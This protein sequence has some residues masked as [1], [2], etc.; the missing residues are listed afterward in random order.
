MWH[1]K[2]QSTPHI[3]VIALCI[4]LRRR[5]SGALNHIDSAVLEA[6]VLSLAGN[7]FPARR[8]VR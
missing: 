5:H 2:F 6:F 7:A 1:E 3:D 4:G 8:P